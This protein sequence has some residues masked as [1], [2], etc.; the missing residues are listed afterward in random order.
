MSDKRG[1]VLIVN[2]IIYATLYVLVIGVLLLLATAILAIPDAL[3]DI[4]NYGDFQKFGRI[5]FQS[6]IL[7]GI[8]YVLIKALQKMDH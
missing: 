4:I 3:S 5:V 8:A 2:K 6:P 7:L 1:F